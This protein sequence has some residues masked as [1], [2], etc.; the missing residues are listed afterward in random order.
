MTV[1]TEGNLE[2]TIANELSVRKFDDPAQHRLSCMAAVDFVVEFADRY[3]FIEVKDPQP[4]PDTRV[5]DAIR[6]HE[7][8]RSGEIDGE[9]KY[10]YRDSFLYEWA[11]GRADKPVYFYVLIALDFLRDAGLLNRKQ[12]LEAVL[13][14]LG[15]GSTEWTRPIVNGCGVF[16]IA[17]WN[18]TFPDYPVRRLP[19]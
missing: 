11:D 17:S 10:K 2:I 9:L 3:L 18:R 12:A 13:P 1:L 14:L 4:N 7:R 16:N 15:P 6:Y 19:S 5:S 8:L